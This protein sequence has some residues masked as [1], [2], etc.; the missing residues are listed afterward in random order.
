MITEVGVV[1]FANRV[2]KARMQQKNFLT[3]P[4][5]LGC[6]YEFALNELLRIAWH[7]F[8]NW[9]RR[10]NRICLMESKHRIKSPITF[11]RHWINDPIS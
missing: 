7:G 9:L 10:K 2:S 11:T 6:K 3:S 5:L 8:K 4:R 1:I